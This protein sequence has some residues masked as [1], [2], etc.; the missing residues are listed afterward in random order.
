MKVTPKQAERLGPD[1]STSEE[2]LNQIPTGL[3]LQNELQY[4]AAF[5]K[6]W[7]EHQKGPKAL[8]VMRDVLSTLP[9]SVRGLTMNSVA[10]LI[11][12][13]NFCNAGGQIAFVD[14]PES[15][16]GSG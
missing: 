1:E 3:D 5:Y 7:S 2:L 11:R 9:D 12:V 8:Q 14:P 16:N 15:E 6:C 10:T 4:V 13:S